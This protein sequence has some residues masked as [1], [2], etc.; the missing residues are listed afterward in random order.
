VSEELQTIVSNARD[1]LKLKFRE[2][3]KND[4]E[5]GSGT[6]DADA[7]RFAIQ[8]DQDSDDFTDAVLRREIRLRMAHAQL[9]ENF[10]GIFP[11]DVDT[12]V[13]PLRNTEGR[14]NELRDAIED[15]GLDIED[16]NETTQRIKVRLGGGA[17][18]TID[19]RRGRMTVRIP[20]TSGALSIIQEFDA[21]GGPALAGPTPKLIGKKEP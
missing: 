8:V 12:L 10:D 15:R 17:R 9:P 18:I 7:F 16:A 5:Q 21:N 14:F 19:M 4:D 3:K 20:A 6:V 11:K 1:I 13:M 2:L